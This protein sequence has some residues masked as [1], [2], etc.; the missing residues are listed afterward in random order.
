M[1]LPTIFEWL[2]RLSS[3]RGMPAV[4]VVLLTAV[5][6]IAA[7]DWRLSIFA[8][9]VQYLFVG[10][11][12]F[13]LLNPRLAVVK[14]L[15]GLF[16][17]LMLYFTGRQV[18][19]GGL[20]PDGLPEEI[21]QSPVLPTIRI[22]SRVIPFSAP[23]R[24]VFVGVIGLMLLFV[25]RQPALHLPILPDGLVAANTAVFLLAILGLLGLV[26]S[27]DPFQAGLGLLM[28]V[29][30]FELYYSGLEQ[31]ISL[32]VGLAAANFGIVLVISYLT[33]VRF[34]F[35]PLYD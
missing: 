16:V 35:S 25:A 27:T 6:I 10:L 18:N 9:M 33:Q 20:P 1:N 23:M 8:L 5:L 26:L 7:I 34:S 29:T 12:F 30:G 14:L 22:G 32:M 17:C 28:F 4:Y 11:L 13:D 24:T 15:V 2:D 3:W 31:S 19:W 21:Q